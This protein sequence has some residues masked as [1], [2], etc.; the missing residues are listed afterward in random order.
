MLLFEFNLS[1]R[2]LSKRTLFYK[3]LEHHENIPAVSIV[4]V[5]K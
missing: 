1:F 2:N 4:V 5:I 3:L